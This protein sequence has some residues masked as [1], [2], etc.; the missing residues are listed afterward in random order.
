MNA[1]SSRGQHPVIDASVSLKWALNDEESVPETAQLRD[2]ALAPSLPI[3]GETLEAS[4]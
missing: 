3:M 1:A 4:K 2:D